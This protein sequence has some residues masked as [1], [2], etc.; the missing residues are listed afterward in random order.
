MKEL[1]VTCNNENGLHMRPAMLVVDAALKFESD[2][3]LVSRKGEASAKSI[4]ETIMLTVEE[5]DEVTIR[6]E[7]SDEDSAVQVIYNI[8]DKQI[9]SRFKEVNVPKI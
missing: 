9:G 2:I 5:G 4:M 3:V 1:K 6:A 8:F 7:G